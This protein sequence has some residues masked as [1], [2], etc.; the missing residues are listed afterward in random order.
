MFTTLQRRF[1]ARG[2]I[3]KN[4]PIFHFKGFIEML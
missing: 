3:R 2:K 1:T 4:Y